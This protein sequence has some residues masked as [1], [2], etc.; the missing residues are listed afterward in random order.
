MRLSRFVGFID[1]GIATVILV[2]VVLPAREMYASA[3]HA[4]TGADAFA[5]ALAEARTIAHPDDGAAIDDLSRR[6]GLVG[7]KDWAVE[8]AVR[9]GERA[10]QSPSRWRALLA[11]SV[12]FV[13][14][15]DVVPALDHA[16]R[17]LSACED[18][19]QACPSWEQVRMKL[20][21]E[22]LDAGVKSGIDPRRGPEAARA[23][24]HAGESAL[25]QIH[26][27]G[28]DVERGSATPA[29]GGG[30]AGSAGNYP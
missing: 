12:A 3:A 16:N 19:P 21:Q 15:L 4:G 28:H 27:G 14:R 29:P 20:Y 8:V 2:M 9:G 1:V 11:A 10:R 30:A 24:R 6:L 5:L 18:H 17:A 22:H 25:R 13:D 7:Q 26:L 23:F